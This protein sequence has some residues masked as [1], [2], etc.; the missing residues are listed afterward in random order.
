MTDWRPISEAPRDGR[1]VEV[2]SD[3]GPHFIRADP[4]G[5]D[6]WWQDQTGDF[7][8]QADHNNGHG[9][10]IWKATPEGFEPFDEGWGYD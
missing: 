9:I 7:C 3:F 6:G 5:E 8:V 2:P 4:E 1:W 10:K